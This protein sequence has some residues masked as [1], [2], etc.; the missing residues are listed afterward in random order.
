MIQNKQTQENENWS[1]TSYTRE[2]QLH[3]LVKGMLLDTY[4]YTVAFLLIY[5]TTGTI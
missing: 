3:T 5:S 2:M 1:P 4:I